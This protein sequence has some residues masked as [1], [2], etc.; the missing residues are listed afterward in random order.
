[1]KKVAEFQVQDSLKKT[2]ENLVEQ[3]WSGYS[4]IVQ[5]LQVE[6][7][8][9]ETR[10]SGRYV[11]LVKEK[12]KI[13][14]DSYKDSS[15]LTYL[16]EFDTYQ[17]LRYTENIID[18]GYPGDIKKDGISWDTL[19]TAPHGQKVTDHQF[20]FYSTAWLYKLYCF[21]LSDISIQKFCYFIP[22]LHISILLLLLFFFCV[23]FFSIE[24]GLVA[25]IL[26]GFSG[27]VMRNS[28]V[29]WYDYDILNYIFPI[30]II[31]LVAE[32]LQKKNIGG[33]AVFSAIA[34][35]LLGLFASHWVG[36][37]FIF[38]L[39]GATLALALANTI[40]LRFKDKKMLWE[41][42]LP[43]VIVMVTFFL[44]GIIFCFLIARINIFAYL[45]HSVKIVLGLGTS[46]HQTIFPQTYYTVSELNPGDF[47]KIAAQLHGIPLFIGAFFSM[48]WVYWK[49]KRNTKADICLFLVFWFAGMSYATMNAIRFAYFL[50]IPCTIFLSVAMVDITT[51]INS[52]CIRSTNKYMRFG[53]VAAA[54]ILAVPVYRDVIDNGR[55]MARGT[56]P[57]MN[58]TWYRE[59]EVIRDSIPSNGIVLT[60]WDYGSW[61]KQIGK[62]KVFIDGHSQERSATHWIARFLMS[63]NEDEAL[64]IV[65]MLAHSSDKIFDTLRTFFDDPYVA[66]SLMNR[67]M[68]SNKD[69]ADKIIR[70]YKV[71]DSLNASLV[72]SL[73][74]TPRDPVYVL[75]YKE[76]IDITPAFSFLGNWE[77]P[78]VYYMKNFSLPKEHL[79]ASAIK[80]FS[81]SKSDAVRLYTEVASVTV[82]KD[83]DEILSS[84]D[85][86]AVRLRGFQD[87]NQVL[88][89]EGVLCDLTKKEAKILKPSGKGFQRP[90]Y[91]YIYDKDS[92]FVNTWGADSATLSE[93]KAYSEKSDTL[94]FGY[95]VSK[96][97]NDSSWEMI[98][99]SSLKLAQSIFTKLM[100]LGGAGLNHFELVHSSEDRSMLLYRVIWSPEKD[101]HGN[102]VKL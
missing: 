40:N 99:F 51:K 12:R 14:A 5:K 29:G 76:M 25:T 53:A 45:Q 78:R 16:S 42:S 34:A 65:K 31:W 95:L 87:G 79:I 85:G 56:L 47:D 86:F 22:L 64:A 41:D 94:P 90:S 26:F 44:G 75:V 93:K 54:I 69:E 17:W 20:L 21:F 49:N 18:H 59:M 60:W 77:Y 30:A 82:K 50:S 96:M 67:L 33:I 7:I 80:L 13:I 3:K 81:L 97:D 63:T 52:L 83:K 43:Y 15:G 35:L 36:W 39:V 89:R 27:L 61:I 6:N 38:V 48:I 2:A 100:F 72:R 68:M 24:A 1:M 11:S 73:Y 84:R 92:L 28:T 102:E 57:I 62:H 55:K 71:P 37:I 4:Q 19:M 8:E 98:S 88:F 74:G 66:I 9:K 23:R 58:D 46:L 10:K 32:A 91:L 101:A 70:S